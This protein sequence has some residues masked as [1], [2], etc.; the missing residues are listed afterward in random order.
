M[1]GAVEIN[2]FTEGRRAGL[3]VVVSASSP[4]TMRFMRSKSLHPSLRKNVH[5]WTVE[6][7]PELQGQICAILASL[8]SDLLLDFNR[9][10]HL[11][12]GEI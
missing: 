12:R 10:R 1:G 6:Q 4:R 8:T 5:P 11:F 2:R 7:S 3:L 9:H